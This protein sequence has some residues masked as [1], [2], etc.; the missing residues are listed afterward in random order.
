[1]QAQGQPVWRQVL[2]QRLCPPSD[3]A[4]DRLAS[5]NHSS[6]R[7]EQTLDV[8][9]HRLRVILE[10]DVHHPERLV[11]LCGWGYRLT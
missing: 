7:L 2:L 6:K 10:T 11:T 3:A 9:I 5:T 4:G 8:Y 1:M